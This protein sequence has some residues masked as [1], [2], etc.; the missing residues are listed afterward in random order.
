MTKMFSLAGEKFPL[1]VHFPFHLALPCMPG[2]S[3]QC[4]HRAHPHTASVWCSQP[5]L[6]CVGG[7]SQLLVWKERFDIH[8]WTTSRFIS[9]NWLNCW[10]CHFSPCALTSCCHGKDSLIFGLATRKVK[11]MSMERGVE[12]VQAAESSRQGGFGDGSVWSC[13]F[14]TGVSDWG[15]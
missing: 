10:P 9:Y 1:A 3:Q 6:F 7:W 15:V 5:W 14:W 8:R 11:R 2:A 13:A 4:F 12:E